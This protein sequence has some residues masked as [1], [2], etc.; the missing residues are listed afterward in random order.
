MGSPGPFTITTLTPPVGQHRTYAYGYDADDGYVYLTERDDMLKL[1]YLPSTM[2]LPRDSDDAV[3][4]TAEHPDVTLF[5][6]AP[7]ELDAMTPE[8]IT[9]P[10]EYTTLSQSERRAMRAVWQG[11]TRDSACDPAERP[12]ISR[13]FNDPQCLDEEEWELM[14]RCDAIAIAA[15]TGFERQSVACKTLGAEYYMAVV[16]EE[17]QTRADLIRENKVK[18]W[19]AVRQCLHPGIG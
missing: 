17:H 6:A 12:N 14:Q 5:T 11:T 13:L 7:Y 10:N 16:N 15:E 19:D 1:R 8:D 18:F 3:V 2:L 9:F 4:F